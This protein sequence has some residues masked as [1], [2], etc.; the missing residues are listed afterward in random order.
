MPKSALLS[1]IHPGNNLMCLAHNRPIQSL[2]V[3]WI[4]VAV[5]ENCHRLVLYFWLKFPHDDS[6]RWCFSN[7]WMEIFR[8]FLNRSVVGDRS[9]WLMLMPIAQALVDFLEMWVGLDTFPLMNK[10]VLWSNYFR[11]TMQHEQLDL[12]FPYQI[13]Y[14]VEHWTKI[15][16]VRHLK[17]TWIWSI[18]RIRHTLNGGPFEKRLIRR[19]SIADKD[20][21]ARC[22]WRNSVGMAYGC[23]RFFAPFINIFASKCCWQMRS[24][25][26]FVLFNKSNRRVFSIQT[27]HLS[28]TNGRKKWIQ[29]E[30]NITKNPNR[31]GIYLL[32]NSFIHNKN[33]L[34]SFFWSE[35]QKP[36]NWLFWV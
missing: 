5:A 21:V 23:S 2:V 25:C 33:F 17:A 27:L 36:R 29:V 18:N 31:F 34:L 7:H 24:S 1:M 32:T 26:T 8:S 30:K 12:P 10:L 20:L 6:C 35:E 19:S 3:M 11:K 4:F 15:K 28:K 14:S 16:C 13:R 9:A 22:V